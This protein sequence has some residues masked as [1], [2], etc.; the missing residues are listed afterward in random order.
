MYSIQTL[1]NRIRA[2]KDKQQYDLFHLL[3]LEQH[4]QLYLQLS[5]Q[6]TRKFCFYLFIVAYKYG[7]SGFLDHAV[8]CYLAILQELE[9][10]EWA[11]LLD[12][13]YRDLMKLLH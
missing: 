2:E 5:P 7:Q 8:K 9:P 11:I 6:Q 12:F 13:I 10:S 3:L 4:A 1:A